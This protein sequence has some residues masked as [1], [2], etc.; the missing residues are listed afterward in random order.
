MHQQHNQGSEILEPISNL[1]RTDRNRGYNDGS[2]IP[3]G[4]TQGMGCSYNRGVIAMAKKK[5][6]Q[7]KA[8]LTAQVPSDPRWVVE[9]RDHFQRTGLYRAE[10]LQRVLGDPRDSVQV[11]IDTGRVLY[12]RFT[13][14]K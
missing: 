9:M 3:M 5:K 12:S 7:A 6:I 11:Q 2:S 4:S 13:S 8:T 1:W 14:S 10:D